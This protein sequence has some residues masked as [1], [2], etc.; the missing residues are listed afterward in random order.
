MRLVLEGVDENRRRMMGMCCV[1]LG[2]EAWLGVGGEMRALPFVVPVAVT[3]LVVV[4]VVCV[5][6]V[7]HRVF[8]VYCRYGVGVSVLAHGTVNSAG[9]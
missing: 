8:A 2:D 3:V 5:V 9:I 6:D 4:V 7:R 1:W